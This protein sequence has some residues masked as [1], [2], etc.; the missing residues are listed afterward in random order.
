M[1]LTDVPTLRAFLERH[2]VSARKGLGQH[3]LCSKRVVDAIAARL[4]GY[5]GALEIGPGPGVLTS[6]LSSRIPHVRAL[7]IDERMVG[8]LA[9]SAPSVEVVRGDALGT[10]LEDLLLDLPTPRA[11]VSNLPYYITGPL[12]TR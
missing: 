10:N 11:I 7:E 1:D 6:A 12:I 5:A 3:F 2:G 8:A 4:E 9:E